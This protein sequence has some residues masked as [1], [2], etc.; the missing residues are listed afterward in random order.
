MA[1]LF[2]E[3]RRHRRHGTDERTGGRD[4]T[5][6]CGLLG[7]LHSNRG[8]PVPVFIRKSYGS[9]KPI[10]YVV[11]RAVKIAYFTRH[12]VRYFAADFDNF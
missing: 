5:L 4:A 8:P 2:Q 11:L 6:L 1:F 3:H 12:V 10:R 9:C 7:G